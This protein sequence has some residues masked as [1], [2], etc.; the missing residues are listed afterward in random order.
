MAEIIVAILEAYPLIDPAADCVRVIC[1]DLADRAGFREV[2]EAM[3]PV[4]WKELRDHLAVVL[5]SAVVFTT[6]V[7]VEKPEGDALDFA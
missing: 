4:D 1:D 7:A 6:P 5:R 3:G 2:V